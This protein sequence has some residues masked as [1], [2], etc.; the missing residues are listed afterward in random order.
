[1]QGIQ[2]PVNVVLVSLYDVALE[3]FDCTREIF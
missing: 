3:N 1:M 2:L